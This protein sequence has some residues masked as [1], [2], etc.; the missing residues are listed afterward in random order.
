M[1][2]SMPIRPSNPDQNAIVVRKKI[3]LI[4]AI[5]AR[6]RRMVEGAAPY[7]LPRGFSFRENSGESPR[8]EVTSAVLSSA[9]EPC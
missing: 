5:A 1:V 3:F 7:G 4:A 9:R 8:R 2:T 6:S